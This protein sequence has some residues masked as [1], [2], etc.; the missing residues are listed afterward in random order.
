[1]PVLDTQGTAHPSPPLDGSFDFYAGPNLLDF[2]EFSDDKQWVMKD[3]KDRLKV[4]A[5]LCEVYLH[6]TTV[7]PADF[8]GLPSES[9]LTLNELMNDIVHDVHELGKS[10]NLAALDLIE[11]SR[12]HASDEFK[13]LVEDKIRDLEIQRDVIKGKVDMIH[14][15]R[16]FQL[17]QEELESEQDCDSNVG[18]HSLSS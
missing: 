8:A 9:L 5:A 15:L 1:M 13:E 11:M 7:Q 3:A 14:G 17:A 18:P 16:E 12:S 10:N 2:V 6:V 4:L